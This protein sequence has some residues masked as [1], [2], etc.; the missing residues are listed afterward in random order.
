M[1][2]RKTKIVSVDIAETLVF[3]LEFSQY[4][5]SLAII[6]LQNFLNG[7]IFMNF[8]PMTL[9]LET[10]GLQLLY[11]GLLYTWVQ[12]GHQAVRAFHSGAIWLV[13]ELL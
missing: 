2:D 11:P 10:Q 9:L 13:K 4:C 6:I 1:M 3:A 12:W 5:L 8:T 7:Q